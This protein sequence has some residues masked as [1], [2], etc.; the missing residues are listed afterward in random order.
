M[1]RAISGRKT[2]H[3]V[4][5]ATPIDRAGEESRIAALAYVVWPVAVYDRIAPRPD[6]SNWYRFHMRQ[7]LWF[8]GCA[9]LAGVAAL[10][11]PL[12][13][14]LVVTSVGITIWMYVFAMAL[15]AVLFVVWLV[16][17]LRYNQRA[18]RGELFEIPWLRRLTGKP[19]PNS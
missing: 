10:L 13:L 2:A 19:A 4:K 18:N 11:W 9:L 14:S 7:S 8:G 12:I 5:I 17:A 3:R 1:G 15:D 16:L 6:A